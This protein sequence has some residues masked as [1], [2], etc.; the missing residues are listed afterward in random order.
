[1]RL[2]RQIK[3]A[4]IPELFRV[5]TA[6]D[7]NPLTLEDLA[8]IDITET[9]VKAK[10]LES[11]KGWLCE[12]EGEVVGFA[13]GDR[14]SGE[15]WVIAVL[16]NYIQQGIGGAL[17]A[18]VDDWLFREGCSELWLVTDLNP[19]L[20][21]YSFYR[22]HGWIDWKIDD[23]LRYMKKKHFNPLLPEV[24]AEID[25]LAALPED[26]IQA[27]YLPEVRD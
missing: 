7:E 20:R 11:Y 1:M 16:P 2:I 22:K 12:D 4:D 9:S 8:E 10:L 26:Q 19:K 13:I 5:R 18:K 27:D 17:L 14:S 25:L 23:G 3:V 6:T 24:Q 15:M 21:A